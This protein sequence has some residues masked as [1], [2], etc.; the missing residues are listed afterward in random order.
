MA[1]LRVSQ[2]GS[3]VVVSPSEGPHLR[4]SEISADVV[5]NAQAGPALR[6]TMISIDVLIDP[7]V[8]PP[9]PEPP[10]EGSTTVPL[11]SLVGLV[12]GYQ[13]MPGLKYDP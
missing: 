3:D 10:V 6:V 2:I 1:D 5:V 4:V 8:D 12:V 11:L 9:P 13:V 7:T